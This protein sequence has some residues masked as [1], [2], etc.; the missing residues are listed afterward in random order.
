MFSIVISH[1]KALYQFNCLIL[2][3]KKKKKEKRKKEEEEEE[4]ERF[5]RHL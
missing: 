4:E 5:V 2:N 1:S 3:Q